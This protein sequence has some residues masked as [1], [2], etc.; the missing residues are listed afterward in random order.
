MEKKRETQSLTNHLH[1]HLPFTSTM[2]LYRNMPGQPAAY[3]EQPGSQT[4]RSFWNLTP[5]SITW[6]FKTYFVQCHRRIQK[7]P[8]HSAFSVNSIDKYITYFPFSIKEK[9]GLNLHQQ[10]PYTYVSFFKEHKKAHMSWTLKTFYIKDAFKPE[11]LLCSEHEVWMKRGK[12]EKKL[13]KKERQHKIFQQHTSTQEH[14]DCQVTIHKE[15]DRR[16][17]SKYTLRFLV[18]E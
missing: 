2:I 12:T 8:P 11:E 15:G 9:L 1:C 10:S 13:N 14:S 16:I 7:S 4:S 5:S 17:H 18:S 6:G 3:E